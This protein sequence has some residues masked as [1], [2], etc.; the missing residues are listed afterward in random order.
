MYTDG[1]L[2]K[3][4]FD[5]P[6]YRDGVLAHTLQWAYDNCKGQV[7]WY[8]DRHSQAIISFE[9]ETDS[10][11]WYLRWIDEYTKKNL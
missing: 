11:I 3:Y 10:I 5:V 7:G 4:H 8:F 6:L 9:K 2:K 1:Y